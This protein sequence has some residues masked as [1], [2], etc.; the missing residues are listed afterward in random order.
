MFIVSFCSWL[1]GESSDAVQQSHVSSSKPAFLA[2]DVL[3]PLLLEVLVR[4]LQL[5]LVIY[6][7]LNLSL[8]C[9]AAA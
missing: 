3:G 8:L 9:T 4:T 6:F 7:F 5:L 1:G 2:N